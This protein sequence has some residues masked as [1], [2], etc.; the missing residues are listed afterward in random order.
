ME[1]Q[2]M[3]YKETDI[4]GEYQESMV[5]HKLLLSAHQKQASRLW[6]SEGRSSFCIDSV[7]SKY[8]Q[9]VRIL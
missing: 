2:H 4:L 3:F 5:S 6:T 7:L 1:D 8:I 9:C